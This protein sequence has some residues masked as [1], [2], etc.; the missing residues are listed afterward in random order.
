[1]ST[2][3]HTILTFKR[4]PL[5]NIGGKGEN[6]GNQHFLLFPQCF[7]LRP[8]EISSLESNLFCCLPSLSIL[9][10]LKIL[11]F[12][13][14]GGCRHLGKM[15]TYVRLSRSTQ[16]HMGQ[17]FSLS[18][19]LSS[20]YTN[21]NSL[22]KKSFRKTLW[23]KVKLLKLSNFTFFHNVFYAI[24]ILKSFN[25]HISGIACSFFEFETVSEW[26]IREWVKFM[27]VK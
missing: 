7:L 25:S 22:N 15:L 23:E 8:T 5:E 19:T 16:T 1:M 13:L 24:C 12:G 4:K 9:T 6:P 11:S 18:L 21:F 14:K 10:S 17:T 26:C 20:L 27:H 2:L 3:Y